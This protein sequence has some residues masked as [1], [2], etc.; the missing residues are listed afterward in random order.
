[1]RRSAPSAI[2]LCTASSSSALGRV[3]A[4]RRQ[5]VGDQLPAV[6]LE[7]ELA[8][9]PGA[10]AQLD[11]GLVERELV[12][13]GREAALAAEVVELASTAT[14]ASSALWWA[15]SSRS[16]PDPGG[17]ERE[18]RL[19]SC[20]AAPMRR[21]CSSP[22]ARSRSAARR[23]VSHT[24]DSASSV[25]PSGHE[26]GKVTIIARVAPRHHPI[27]DGCGPDLT[28]RRPRHSVSIALR[29]PPAPVPRCRAR[30]V[31]PRGPDRRAVE[32]GAGGRVVRP[33]PPGAGAA[34]QSR[35]PTG[36][37]EPRAQRSRCR[38]RGRASVHVDAR[39]P[40]DRLANRHVGAA[41]PAPRR[42][43]PAGRSSSPSPGT[44]P[45][46]RPE[47]PMTEQT[48]VIVGGASPERRRPR[49]C[50]TDG[51]DGRVVL[52]GGEHEDPTIG[53][54]SRR[55]TCAARSPRTSCGSTSPGSTA[56]RRSS[57]GPAT[58]V[59]ARRGRARGRA[60]GRRARRV[61]PALLATGAE[62]RAPHAARRR[63]RRACTTCAPSPTPT[64]SPRA[65]RRR[66]GSR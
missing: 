61:R 50:A 27:G 5:A 16:P 49:P 37:G 15:R 11:R 64:R 7:R 48:F 62:P 56:T 4:G 30:R 55:S 57:C 8:V 22:T 12:G 39:R 63:A 18:R 1:M 58:H 41:R 6:G 28:C 23:R 59:V 44:R 35:S 32:A 26:D 51:F 10:A 20:R 14:S 52:V 54:R 24:R 29:A 47:E 40:C 2:A 19:T 33:R 25:R 36:S 66:R 38:A 3:V 43:A 42:R 60:R 46:T 9:L 13:P 21:P 34:H 65:S 45:L 31:P 17:N 53:R